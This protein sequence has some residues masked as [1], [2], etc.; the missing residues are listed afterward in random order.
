MKQLMVE[1]D[2]DIGKTSVF[3]ARPIFLRV[4]AAASQYL[5]IKGMISVARYGYIETSYRIL[6]SCEMCNAN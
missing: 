1:L 5:I 4:T 3:R 2:R 6:D